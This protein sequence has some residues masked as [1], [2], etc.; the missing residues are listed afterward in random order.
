MPNKKII[1]CGSII[2]SIGA[3]QPVFLGEDD[4]SKINK[5]LI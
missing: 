3:M 2:F 5:S 4:L 1:I